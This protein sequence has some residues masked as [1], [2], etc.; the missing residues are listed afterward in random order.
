MAAYD[1]GLLPGEKTVRRL[2]VMLGDADE[3]VQANAAVGLARQKSVLG[4]PVLEEIL[5]TANAQVEPG[6]ESEFYKFLS[7]KNCVEAIRRLEPH[8]SPD[9]KAALIVLLAPVAKGFREPRIRVDAGQVLVALQG[10]ASGR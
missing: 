9:Q 10:S 1:L 5:K 3:S 6:S 7:L 2:E 8:L 4:L